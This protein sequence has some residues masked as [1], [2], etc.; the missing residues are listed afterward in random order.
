MSEAVASLGAVTSKQGEAIE[1]ANKP[2]P[3]PATPVQKETT[4]GAVKQ[5]SETPIT[6]TPEQYLKVEKE[7]NTYKGRYSSLLEENKRLK[8]EQDKINAAKEDSVID[9]IKDATPEQKAELKAWK[10]K[11]RDEVKA[12]NDL[13]AKHAPILAALEELGI[14]DAESLRQ[15]IQTSRETSFTQMVNTIAERNNVSAELLKD[16]AAK[17]GVKDEAGINELA[18]VMPK[19]ANIPAPD[20][21]KNVG[22]VDLS[23]LSPEEK[24]R[25]GREA[26]K[27]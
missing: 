10:A 23:K 7:A 21:G 1:G 15:T 26:Q 27:K 5:T 19:K 9:D 3:S 25:R 4:P 17:L 8:A 18:L 6:F 14:T 13:K 20:S 2:N 22:G 16:K 24:F 12:F 11:Q